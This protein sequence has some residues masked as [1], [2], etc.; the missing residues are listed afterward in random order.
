M[1]IDT[2]LSLSGQHL[3][4]EARPSHTHKV[5]GEVILENFKEPSA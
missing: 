5:L 4:E 2:Y 3:S 1:S